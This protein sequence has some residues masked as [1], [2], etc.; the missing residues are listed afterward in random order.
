MYAPGMMY[1][2]RAGPSKMIELAPLSVSLVGDAGGGGEED[3]GGTNAGERIGPSKMSAHSLTLSVPGEPIR[4]G[5]DGVLISGEGGG[6]G[7]A[8][9]E[10]MGNI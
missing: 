10:V 7:M 9:V 4:V 3:G 2:G 8:V 1:L 6:G 5:V